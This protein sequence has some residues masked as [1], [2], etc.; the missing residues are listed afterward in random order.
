MA[1][2]RLLEG[3]QMLRLASHLTHGLH[4]LRGQ[5]PGLTDAPVIS[6][7]KGSCISED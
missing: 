4:Q 6:W 2:S 3:V 5:T 7:V 1:G